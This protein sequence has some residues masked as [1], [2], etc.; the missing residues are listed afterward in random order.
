MNKEVRPLIYTLIVLVLLI[1]AYPTYLFIS[2]TMTE[3][4]IERLL[5]KAEYNQDIQKKEMVFESM[6]GRYVL[7]INYT[8]EPDYTYNYEIVGD[9]V[10]TTVYDQH[11]VEVTAPVRHELK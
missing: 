7:E 9:Q 10:L 4:K 11:N 5:A 2:K 8:N 3:I 1:A 6:T